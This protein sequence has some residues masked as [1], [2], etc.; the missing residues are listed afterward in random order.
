MSFHLGRPVLVM[1]VLA[2]I[3]GATA[4]SRRSARR[5]DLTVWLLR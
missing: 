1:I 2:L 4:L 5:A 3:A